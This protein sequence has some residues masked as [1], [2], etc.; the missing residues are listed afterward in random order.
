MERAAVRTS[1]V[2]SGSQMVIGISEMLAINDKGLAF[3]TTISRRIELVDQSF[4]D[5]A[6]VIPQSVRQALVSRVGA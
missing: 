6:V 5:S 3:T 4:D 1:R 2:K